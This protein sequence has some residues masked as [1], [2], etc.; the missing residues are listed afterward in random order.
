MAHRD[1]FRPEATNSL[2]ILF[3]SFSEAACCAL[4][5]KL[6]EF[7][8]LW[9]FTAL[10]SF[11][12]CLAVFSC[13]ADAQS[14]RNALNLTLVLPG[15]KIRMYY[16]MH[17]PLSQTQDS[18][19]HVPPQDKLWLISPPGSP[20]INWRQTR[21]D[22]PNV[23]HLERRLEEALKEL[24][25]GQFSLNPD[26]VADYDSAESDAECTQSMQGIYNPRFTI[27]TGGVDESSDFSDSAEDTPSHTST[28]RAPKET[29]QSTH[30]LAPTI[31]IQNYDHAD[32]DT[33]CSQDRGKLPTDPSSSTTRHTPAGG[34]SLANRP[35]TPSLFAG[36]SFQP[37][38]R[39][40]L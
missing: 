30:T 12:R 26:D 15:N 35:P 6:E 40:P 23:T 7:G 24:S 31:I 13:T 14:A 34:S 37:T 39:P 18:F 33:Q 19:L 28:K 4:R 22:P 32:T 29:Q 21:E 5:S 17:T 11:E 8:S 38:P 25:V 9:H 20:P 10:R 16:S 2:V 1:S 36:S 3:D 27:A